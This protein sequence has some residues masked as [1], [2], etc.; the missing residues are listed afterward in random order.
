MTI[1]HVLTI[2]WQSLALVE[3]M[4]DDPLIR[5]IISGGASREQYLTF[6]RSTYHYL[7]WSGSLLA[8]GAE[9]LRKSGHRPKVCDVLDVQMHEDALRNG[10]LL[11][12]IKAL[13]ENVE[14]VK[15][16]AIPT[17][18]HAYVYRTW[19]MAKGTAFF[20]AAYTLMFVSMH[21]AKAAAENLRA[22]GEIPNI[23]DAVSFLDAQAN[24]YCRS[25]ERWNDILR[26]IEDPHEQAA[27][28][29]SAATIR[30]LYPQFF[31]R[32]TRATTTRLPAH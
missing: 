3:A 12:D 5:S 22:R 16:S 9:D 8:A 13:G 21:R 17:A 11:N 26:Q 14:V 19:R 15:A 23:E 27:I 18:V 28:L 30:G 1:D 6:L 29:R 4:D 24:A 32:E 2:E 10:C 7:R 25:L 20:G 31:R